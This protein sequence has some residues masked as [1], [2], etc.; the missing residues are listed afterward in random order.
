[1]WLRWLLRI[2]ALLRGAALV[3]ALLFCIYFACVQVNAIA[4]LAGRGTA[5][6]GGMTPPVP[7][8]SG[9]AAAAD[10]LIGLVIEGFTALVATIAIAMA[11]ARLRYARRR[12]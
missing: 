8:R 3:M 11:F 6:I 1:M 2:R 12:S 5:I 7:I 9:A 4:Y 10:I